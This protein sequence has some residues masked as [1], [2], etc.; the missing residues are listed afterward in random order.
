[1]EMSKLD[2]TM[3]DREMAQDIHALSPCPWPSTPTLCPSTP[4]LMILM[5]QEEAEIKGRVCRAWSGRENGAGTGLARGGKCWDRSGVW[6]VLGQVWLR[7]VCWDRSGGASDV[8]A[9]VL[10]AISF[11]IHMKFV[12]VPLAPITLLIRNFFNSH[13]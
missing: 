8:L 5:T 6:G 4:T 13:A 12:K 2:V 10:R 3:Y 7:G 1:M 11:F 9:T